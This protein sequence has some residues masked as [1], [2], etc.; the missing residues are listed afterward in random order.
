M[1]AGDA[2]P[3]WWSCCWGHV[4]EH[5][6]VAEDD[7]L[8]CPAFFDDEEP[9]GTCLSSSRSPRGRRP[10][11]LSSPVRRGRDGHRGPTETVRLVSRLCNPSIPAESPDRRPDWVRRHWENG[12]RGP[13]SMRHS[14]ENGAHGPTSVRRIAGAAT[15]RAGWVGR[16]PVL[17]L[18]VAERGADRVE[19]AVE[20]RRRAAA[21]PVGEP[22][23][24]PL[25]G[26]GWSKVAT[27][28]AAPRCSR[29]WRRV[30]A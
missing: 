2:Q 3:H 29:S 4:F 26:D 14:R 30:E 5:D 7:E 27:A 25:C 20:R 6:P 16:D 13:T 11:T 22:A 9:C 23:G 1:T 8:R 28:T 18:P 12:H 21:P 15:Q 10:W 17:V 19:I 24:K